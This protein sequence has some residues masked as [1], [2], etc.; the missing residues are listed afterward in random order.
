MT[1]LFFL[2]AGAA[3]VGLAALLV[4]DAFRVR[5]HLP[6]VRG[7]LAM[8]LAELEKIRRRLDRLAAGD[9]STSTSPVG[10]ATGDLTG[11]VPK[12]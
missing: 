5:R 7:E 1:A 4:A 2:T 6:H 12:P 8:T 10:D 11:R 9:A 3:V